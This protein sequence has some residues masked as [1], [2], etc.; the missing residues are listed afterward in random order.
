M[1]RLWETGAIKQHPLR[2]DPAPRTEVQ[3]PRATE[4]PIRFRRNQ[5]DRRDPI[6][7]WV[8]GTADASN[9]TLGNRD[10]HLLNHENGSTGPIFAQVHVGTSG[11]IF[12]Q[13]AERVSGTVH[14]PTA[15]WVMGIDLDS[16]WNW[17]IGTDNASN[18]TL[19]NRDGHLLN[20]ENGSTGPIFAQL[21]FG[22]T[23]P[24]IPQRHTGSSGPIFAQ[25]E[26]A[27][28]GIGR[29]VAQ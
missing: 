25:A 7:I 27:F 22:S 24:K 14:S 9:R 19:G 6:P 17:V 26:T 29:Y 1:N 3:G 4:F 21:H 8:I 16:I 12:P 28:S 11:S 2:F 18:R 10:G 23:G 15:L 13:R 20:H 5:P